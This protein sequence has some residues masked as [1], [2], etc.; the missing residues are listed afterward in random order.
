M[1]IYVEMAVC[2]R[3][4]LRPLAPKPAG[5]HL[6]QWWEKSI[7]VVV[8]LSHSSHFRLYYWFVC[9]IVHFNAACF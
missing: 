8:V 4:E 3:L 6:F 2:F 1:F 9:L 7:V 5:P